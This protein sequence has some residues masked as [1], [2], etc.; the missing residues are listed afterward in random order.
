[1]SVYTFFL[2]VAC[3]LSWANVAVVETPPALAAIRKKTSLVLPQ[4]GASVS[5][6]NND[7]IVPGADGL[8]VRA[9]PEPDRIVP[10]VSNAVYDGNESVS[11]KLRKAWKTVAL[12]F[13]SLFNI[14]LLKL[15]SA[16]DGGVCHASME[17]IQERGE[18]P[19]E[20][21]DINA[22]VA[23]AWRERV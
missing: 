8:S 21:V 9:A 11:F 10:L 18:K 19:R 1:M 17:N 4:S 14:P 23:M 13:T 20:K 2:W 7:F 6:L 15:S 16:V 12:Q 22:M 3:D 5:V